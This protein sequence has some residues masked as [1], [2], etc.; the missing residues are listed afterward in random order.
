MTRFAGSSIQRTSSIQETWTV[1][2]KGEQAIQAN[3]FHRSRE[4][5]RKGDVTLSFVP[6]VNIVESVDMVSVDRGEGRG[7]ASNQGS[8]EFEL[9]IAL[10]GFGARWPQWKP[11]S[12]RDWLTGFTKRMLLASRVFIRIISTRVPFSRQDREH[13]PLFRDCFWILCPRR[14]RRSIDRSTRVLD[15]RS[16]PQWNGIIR[17]IDRFFLDVPDTET[18]IGLVPAQEIH[19]YSGSECCLG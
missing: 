7:R 15:E 5:K 10:V 6:L 14:R 3:R 11:P 19:N 17:V 18:T 13:R 4:K 12:E 2:S 1:S 8:R 16:L 9:E